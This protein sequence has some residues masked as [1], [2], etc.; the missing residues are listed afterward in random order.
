MKKER[1]IL[2][3][4]KAK[5]KEKLA[6][7]KHFVKELKDRCHDCHTTQDLVYE[8]LMRAENDVQYYEG[9]IKAINSRVKA[10]AAKTGH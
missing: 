6:S 2:R 5:Y 10:L 4:E 7:L 8:D 9:Q 3:A 1:N